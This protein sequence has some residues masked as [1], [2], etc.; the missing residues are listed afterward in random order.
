MSH[1][2]VK[3]SIAEL[4]SELAQTPE[5]TSQFEEKL[6]QAKDGIERYTPEAVQE[7]V[8]TLQRE[9]E[10]F[11]VEHPRITALINQVTTALS[12]LGI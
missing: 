5:E 6:E 1:K 10:E 7:L 12:N 9:A 2:E 3:K 4:K 8:Q 11:E